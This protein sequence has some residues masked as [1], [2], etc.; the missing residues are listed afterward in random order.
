MIEKLPYWPGIPSQEG[1]PDR[2]LWKKVNEVIEAVNEMDSILHQAPEEPPSGCVICRDE[3]IPPIRE[4]HVHHPDGS[5]FIPKFP[6]P[7][8]DGDRVQYTA[9]YL[10]LVPPQYLDEMAARRGTVLGVTALGGDSRSI[11][12]T[13]QWDHGDIGD[14]DL[15]YL[16]AIGETSVLP[17]PQKSID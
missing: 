12:V 9:R 5:I 3:G 17:D 1:H 8:Q 16:M 2:M 10:E 13:V 15:E 11:L 14:A 7:V 4:P 6:F